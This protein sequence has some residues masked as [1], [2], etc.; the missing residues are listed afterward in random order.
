MRHATSRHKR[1][2]TASLK[3][4]KQEPQKGQY[5]PFSQLAILTKAKLIIDNIKDPRQSGPYRSALEIIWKQLTGEP[6]DVDK[7]IE[8]PAEAILTLLVTP[9]AVLS[10]ADLRNLHQQASEAWA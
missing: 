9:E 7:L 2:L 1:R 5:L 6:I 8:N 4:Q 3:H 10:D